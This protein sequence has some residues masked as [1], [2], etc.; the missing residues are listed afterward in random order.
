[1]TTTGAELLAH[2]FAAL[3]AEEQ[4][5]AFARIAD[6]RVSRLAAQEDERGFFLRSLRMVADAATAN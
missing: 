6:A 2:A 4:E 5:E 1:M 3:P